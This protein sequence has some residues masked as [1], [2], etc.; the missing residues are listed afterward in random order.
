MNRTHYADFE[1]VKMG[2][3]FDR[4]SRWKKKIRTLIILPIV[5]AILVAVRVFF[6][7]RG[8][9][10][11][12]PVDG[13]LMLNTAD[14]V[15]IILWIGAYCI[16]F[17]YC[18]IRLIVVLSRKQKYALTPLPQRKMVT[19]ITQ[20]KPAEAAPVVKSGILAKSQEN[21]V[22]NYDDSC[23][24]PQALAAFTEFCGR[25]LAGFTAEDATKL[26][27]LMASTRLIY[28]SGDVKN[29]VLVRALSCWFGTPS[30]MSGETVD[31]LAPVK[32]IYPTSPESGESSFAV[33]VYSATRAPE[34]L[35]V[36]SEY[37]VHY[38]RFASYF[39]DFFAYAQSGNE[40]SVPF[41]YYGRL[42]NLPGISGGRLTLP[43]NMWFAMLGAEPNEFEQPDP[44]HSDKYGVMFNGGDYAVV[45][46]ENGDL[47]D[48]ENNDKPVSAIHMTNLFNDV[49]TEN[50]VSL[51]LWNKFDKLVGFIEKNKLSVKID[52]IVTRRLEKY[53]SVY[54]ACGY[55]DV[56]ALD[57]GIAALVVPLLSGD[58]IA[59]LNEDETEAISVFLDDLFGIGNTEKTQNALRAAGVVK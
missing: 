42:I 13:L 44:L 23:D 36:I 4:F 12:S 1:G 3:E 41:D 43:A 48:I 59:K 17:T 52:N 27:A 7:T 56:A 5:F 29:A 55:E 22:L 34:S 49:L 40:C 37:N 45:K 11:D 16:F 24:L 9:Y 35:R 26:F 2:K 8:E 58:D 39:S 57:E 20:D 54:V 31:M 32:L 6:L 50:F 21:R 10:V 53:S 46:N 51:E 30:A 19:D 15:K 14:Q 47:P 28:F 33:D 38:T 25:Y 18:F